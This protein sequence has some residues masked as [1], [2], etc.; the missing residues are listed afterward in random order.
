MANCALRIRS[1]VPAATDANNPF[2]R[3]DI[4]QLDSDLRRN[5]V[6]VC[7]VD[8]RPRTWN[9]PCESRVNVLLPLFDSHRDS[10]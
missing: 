3:V 2:V 6:V 1:S 10:V 5:R 7:S 8:A 9:L 4:C